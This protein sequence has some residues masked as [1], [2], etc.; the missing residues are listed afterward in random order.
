MV[1]NMYKN[2]SDEA[3][4]YKKIICAIDIHRKAI[5]YIYHILDL[6]YIY[7]YIFEDSPIFQFQGIILS[8]NL[9][10]VICLGLNFFQISAYK[11][12]YNCK[13]VIKIFYM[14]KYVCVRMRACVCVC[15]VPAV[16]IV[17]I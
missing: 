15:Y 2:V 14:L 8:F 4:I 7:I 13:Y 10:G 5:Y 11:Y 12:L 16:A 1:V 6:I 3:M 17:N 9:V